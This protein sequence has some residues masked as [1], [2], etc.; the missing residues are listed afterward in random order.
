MPPGNPQSPAARAGDLLH[1]AK[2]LHRDRTDGHMFPQVSSLVAAGLPLELPLR[3]GLVTGNLFEL[4][5]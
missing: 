5:S 4:Y 1:N 2:A 3:T